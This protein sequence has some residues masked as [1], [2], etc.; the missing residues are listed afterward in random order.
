[1]I[2][3]KTEQEL[4]LMRQ[5]GNI[6]GR[7]LQHVVALVT[8]KVTT[9]ELDDAAAAFLKAQGAQP[10]FLGYRGYPAVICVSVND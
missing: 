1:M 10:A 8:P 2:E 7:L 5:A 4:G 9:G 3:L 6:V